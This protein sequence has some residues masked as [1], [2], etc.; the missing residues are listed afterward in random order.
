MGSD[1]TP[2]TGR[3]G[4]MGIRNAIMAVMTKRTGMP[5]WL[6]EIQDATGETDPRRVRAAM[7]WLVRDPSNGVTVHTRSQAWVYRPV[8]MAE[9]SR[10]LLEVIG[11]SRKDGSRVAEGEDGT[12]YRCVPI[13]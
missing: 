4:V 13:N 9:A 7:A 10:E 5:V 6:A 12:L 2:T 3:K 8:I 11:T 1:T